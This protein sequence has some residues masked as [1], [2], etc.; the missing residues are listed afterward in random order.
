[1]PLNAIDTSDLEKKLLEHPVFAQVLTPEAMRIFLA[2]HVFAVWD[3]L[4]LV[5]A[6]QRRFTCVEVPWTPRGEPGLRRLVNEVVLDEESDLGP[7]GEPISHFELYR[8][9][10]L[11][12]GVS[13]EPIDTFLGELRGGSAPGP[14]LKTA[15]VPQAVS[16]F[17]ETTLAWTTA[18]DHELAGAF[19]FGREEIIPPT[20]QRV[21]GRIADFDPDR[22]SRFRYYL[23]RHIR[24]DS[25]K[26]GPL[27]R[28]LV[29]D[30]CGDEPRRWQE[31]QEAARQSLRA[32]LQLFDHI[33][34]EI[35][36][37]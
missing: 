9:A 28:Q 35:A 32:R 26:H 12:S 31:A 13:T 11:D 6:L 16:H 30:L 24:C 37:T 21:V 27:A 8:Q 22:W 23:E 33:A 5:K 17:V 10:M 36:A 15:R 14:A 18:S 34:D 3:F 2:S 29:A 25:E 1:M 19:A 7:D 4:S 20:F